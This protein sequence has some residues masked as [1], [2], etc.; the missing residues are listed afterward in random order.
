MGPV[1]GKKTGKEKVAET[2]TT[3]DTTLNRSCLNKNVSPQSQQ[4]FSRWDAP[5]P[6]EPHKAK[7]STRVQNENGKT[8]SDFSAILQQ[9]KSWLPK[10]QV[11]LRWVV[12]NLPSHL[13]ILWEEPQKN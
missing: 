12:P 8:K 13:Y 1:E 10:Q 9:I 6:R 5:V 4:D 7:S 2:K 3:D 11:L